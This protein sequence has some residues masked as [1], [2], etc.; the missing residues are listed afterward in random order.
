MFLVH[1]MTGTVVILPDLRVEIGRHKV[2]DLEKVAHRDLIERSLHLQIALRDKKLRLLKH[3]VV[4]TDKKVKQQNNLSESKI[5]EIIRKVINENSPKNDVNDIDKVTKAVNTGVET[6][7]NSLRDKLNS[8]NITVPQ[9]NQLSDINIDADKLA[10][11]RHKSVEQ[12]EIETGGSNKG[13]KVNIVNTSIH[14][15]ADEL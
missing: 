5:E 6:I 8:I 2:F 13:K 12:L 4:R 10:E 3:S 15:I 1:N 11:I 14:D 7:L 9:Q